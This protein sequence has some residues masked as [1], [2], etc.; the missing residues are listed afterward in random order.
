[1]ITVKNCKITQ[2]YSNIATAHDAIHSYKASVTADSN[3]VTNVP[4]ILSADSPI[5]VYIHNALNNTLNNAYIDLLSG[6][7][8][9]IYNNVVQNITDGAIS[10]CFGIAQGNAPS[11]TYNT[12]HGGVVNS[13]KITDDGILITGYGDGSTNL[14]SPKVEH[15]TTDHVYDACIEFVGQWDSSGGTR[16]SI[17]DNNCSDSGI[18]VGGWYNFS[19]D[20][21]TFNGNSTTRV[22]FPEYFFYTT[23]AGCTAIPSPFFKHIDFTYDQNVSGTVNNS[24]FGTLGGAPGYDF[25]STAGIRF[26]ND[27]LG[28]IY[29]GSSF[30]TS[31]VT[32]LGNNTCGGTSDPNL[33]TSCP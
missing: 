11:I 26:S 12:C 15:N 17:A 28:A 23:C 31:T 30:T 18:G 32:D 22:G 8:N 4:I 7:S 3:T 6:H 20:T 21:A 27:D 10:F 33:T 29:W 2:D 13:T 25:A 9:S 5:S 19:M 24:Y 1:M 14:T 16:G